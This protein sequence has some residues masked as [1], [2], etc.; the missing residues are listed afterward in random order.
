MALSQA[1]RPSDF[2]ALFHMRAMNFK[3]SNIFDLGGNI[4][5]L[6]YLYD[7]YLNLPPDCTWLVYEL[8]AWV[9][10]GKKLATDRSENRL[11]FTQKWEDAAGAELLIRPLA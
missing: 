7:R 3:N 5:N 9:E 11:R 6:F 4:G 10:A 1:A 8:P 2:A